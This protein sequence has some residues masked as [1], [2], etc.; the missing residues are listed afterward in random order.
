MN[1]EI[2]TPF[3]KGN[4]DIKKKGV[5]LEFSKEQ[6]EEI[7]KCYKDINYFMSNYV[8]IISLDKG[9]VLFDAYDFQKKMVEEFNKNRFTICTLGRQLRKNYYSLCVSFIPGYF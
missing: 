4:P 5:K 9:K 7:Y 8:Y 6:I 3:Y 1:S 2:I